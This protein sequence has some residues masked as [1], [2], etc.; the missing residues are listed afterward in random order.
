MAT[1]AARPVPA[2]GI[3]DSGVGGLSVALEIQRA[4]PEVPLRYLADGAWFPYGPRPVAEIEERSLVLARRLVAEG[5]GLVVVA[6]NT[7]TSAALPRLRTELAIPI[8]GMEPP[9]K[10]AVARSRTRRVLVL[11]TPGTAK[12]ERLARLAAEHGGDAQVTVVAMPGLADLVESGEIRG[13]RVEA[14]VDAALAGADPEV[15]QV[16]LGCTHYAFLRPVLADRFG[17][18]VELVEAGAPVARRVASLLG[19]VPLA[20]PLH[21]PLRV[22]TTGDRDR[23]A[24][25]LARLAE[26]G[27]LL[28]GLELESDGP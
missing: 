6:C 7:A 25:T 12:G 17:A 19:L 22:A 5:C 9:L 13:A 15:D 4:L 26:E 10:P 2:I 20:G 28:P 21:G 1:S 11:A 3:F 16:V 8:V 24:R 14:L 23:L 27:A 18:G